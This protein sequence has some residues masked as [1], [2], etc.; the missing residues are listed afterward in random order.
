MVSSAVCSCVSGTTSRLVTRCITT[1]RVSR[2][3]LVQTPAVWSSGLTKTYHASSVSQGLTLCAA[4]STPPP[5]D[6]SHD[7]ASSSSWLDELALVSWTSQLDVC[8]MFVSCILCF[9]HASYLFD[10]CSTF[11]RCLLDVCLIG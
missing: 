10:V 7:E 2:S 6:L 4:I 5:V 11:A 3:R 1:V 8:L 9:M